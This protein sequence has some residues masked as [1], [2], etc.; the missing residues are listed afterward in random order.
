MQVSLQSITKK[1]GRTIALDQV[2]LALEP[3]SVLALLG[4]NG[5]GKTTLLRVL[6]GVAGLNRLVIALLSHYWF[7]REYSFRTRWEKFC[8]RTKAVWFAVSFRIGIHNHRRVP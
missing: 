7:V 3:E 2:T 5:A 1:Y 8:L 6:C 4:K